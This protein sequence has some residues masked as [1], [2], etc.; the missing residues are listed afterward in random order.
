MKLIR[1]TAIVVHFLIVIF[2]VSHVYEYVSSPF[3]MGMVYYY[4][5][6][7][8]TN[9]CFGFFAPNV[10][11][12]LKIEMKVFAEGDTFDYALSKENF[13]VKTRI[14]SLGGNFATDNDQS[15][16]DLFARSWGLKAINENPGVEKV[17]IVVFQNM[18]PT[19]KDFRAGAR[20]RKDSLYITDVEIK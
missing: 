20:I 3:S 12:D 2:T 18:I 5:A 4:S 19:H 17:N 16:M 9:R 13:E 14:Y 10:G 11:S 7:T 1:R 8:Y 6:I 15:V